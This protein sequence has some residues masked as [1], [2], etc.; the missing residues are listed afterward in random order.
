MFSKSRNVPA[1]S[2]LAMPCP[3]PSELV[4]CTC[5]AVSTRLVN[6][7]V[8][9]R[10]LLR[11]AVPLMYGLRSGRLCTASV[12]SRE[13]LA[14]TGT[15]QRPSTDHLRSG[16]HSVPLRRPGVISTTE[17]GTH[18]VPLSQ[19]PYFQHNH[20]P[21]SSLASHV[22][23]VLPPGGGLEEE[24]FDFDAGYV[25]SSKL[26]QMVANGAY[27]YPDSGSQGHTE[28]S[29]HTLTPPTHPLHT[30]SQPTHPVRVK[31]EPGLTLPQ[32]TP[33]SNHGAD[34]LMTLRVKSEPGVDLPTDSCPHSN[35][36]WAPTIKRESDDTLPCTHTDQQSTRPSV[37]VKSEPGSRDKKPGVKSEDIEDS[38]EPPLWR[39][40]YENICQMRRER[41]APVDTHGCF[42]LAERDVPPHVRAMVFNL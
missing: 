19:S 21:F 26:S 8:V 25:I 23:N 37:K 42:M 10:M 5:T 16:T 12:H 34:M 33:T 2:G 15:G 1:L 38:W 20:G 11:L 17:P 29:S 24:E 13:D 36:G 6:Q 7:S 32:A 35:P 22:D 9:W 14:N 31:I 28:L 41:T 3:W 4:K 18:S 30:P 39:V 27:S 40:Q